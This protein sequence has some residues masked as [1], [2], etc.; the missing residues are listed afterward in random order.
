MTKVSILQSNS[1][2]FCSAIIVLFSLLF[3]VRSYSQVSDCTLD[4]GGK[5]SR[6]IIE[7]F[8]LNEEQQGLLEEWTAELRTRSE[9]IEEKIQK[10]L[11][12]HPQ[13]TEADLLNLAKKYAAHKDELMALS[14]KYDQKLL[15]VF[16]E[17]QYEFY[18]ELCEEAVRRPLNPIYPQ[19]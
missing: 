3:C 5:D 1:R 19:E 18:K 2:N 8:Q 15:G 13:S 6:L 14:L 16:N 4:I 10:L 9:A 7:I 17:K 11:D 12:H